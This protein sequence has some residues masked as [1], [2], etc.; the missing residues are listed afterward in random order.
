MKRF[1]PIL[2]FFWIVQLQV[3]SSVLTDYLQQ[4]PAVVEVQSMSPNSFFTEAVQVKIR[5][6]LDHGQPGKG[7]FIQRVFI[8]VLTPQ[9]PVVL[10]TEGYA[11][12]YGAN[13]AYLNELCPLINSSQVVVEHRYFGQSWPDVRD[14]SYLTVENA[15]GDH[16]KVVELLKPFLTGT[17]LNTGISKGGQTALLHR[18]F[19]PDDVDVTVSYV[20][21]FNF[22]VEDGRHE[23]Y[24]RK[25]VG[26][27]SDRKKVEAFQQEL[28]K[29]REQLMPLFEKHA[30]EKK[31]T[32][33]VGLN[34]VYDYCVLEYSFAFWQWGTHPGQIPSLSASD[35]EVFTH[36]MKISGPDYFSLEGL[37]RIGSFFVQAA[38]ELGYYGYDTRPFRRRLT[39][40]NADNYLERLFLPGD[41]RVE[42]D[43]TSVQ[44]TK[45]FLETTDARMIFIYGANDPWTA[46][47][48]DLPHRDNFLRIVQPGASHGIRISGLDDGNK[49]KAIN[50]LREWVG[51]KET[52]YHPVQRTTIFADAK[53]W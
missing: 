19:Y 15:A 48:V 47:G 38:R 33:G 42:F 7:S 3:Q 6:P 53:L 35:E 30:E 43:D 23:P 25:S 18:V 31:I 40:T 5:Q 49:E 52:A 22:G 20:A 32:F 44:K 39:I 14:W 36:F 46:S 41:Y 12:N 9:S 1:L 45:A 16:H 2:F 29:R 10:V 8:S 17:W 28:L 51:V 34:E 21:P 24:I 4:F 37:E 50:R 11:A 27:R 13:P 26:T